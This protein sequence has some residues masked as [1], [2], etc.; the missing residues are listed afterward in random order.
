MAGKSISQLTLAENT[1]TS[2]L[3]ETTIYSDSEGGLVSRKNTIGEIANFIIQSIDPYS[4]VEPNAGAHNS[5]YRGKN[6]GSSVSAAQYD[7]IDAGTFNDLFIGDYWDIDDVTWRI[8]A[9]DYYLGSGSTKTTTHHVTIV[10]DSVLVNLV[11]MNS[12]RTTEGG[13]MNSE[14]YTT[15]MQSAKDIVISAFG[16]SHILNHYKR[17]QNATTDGVDSGSAWAESKIEIMDE[18]NVYGH[19][20]SPSTDTYSVDQV[21]YPLFSLNPS[22]ITTRNHYWLR[23]VL[24]N[25]SF[26]SHN[27]IGAYVGAT[28]EATTRG[29]RPQF[30]ICKSN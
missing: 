13:Y 8:A 14:M 29:I 25:I 22:L 19:L 7:E 3:I 21:Q 24:S 1:S 9:F 27:S 18:R 5:I 28:A 11:P 6:L 4:M 2:D 23:N 20:Y 30:S 17:L 15:N 12:T 10:P 16:S 26:G